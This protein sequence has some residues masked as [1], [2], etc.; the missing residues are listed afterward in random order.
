M[1]V[2]YRCVGLIAL[3]FCFLLTARATAEKEG[4]ALSDHHR[5]MKGPYPDGIS[6]TK[7]CIT[8]HQKAAQEV[9]SSAHW[10]W[11]G[12]SP[13]VEGREDRTDL[14]KINLVNNF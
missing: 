3:V 4:T 6:V 13:F 11:R 2:S 14:G 8:C 10:L 1:M 9:M 5:Y 12:P 7:D